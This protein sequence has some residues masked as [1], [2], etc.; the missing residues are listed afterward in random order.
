MIKIFLRPRERERK[1]IKLI[2]Q[3]YFKNTARE[4]SAGGKGEKKK[5]AG[6]GGGGGDGRKC[7]ALLENTDTA[8]EIKCGKGGGGG[9]FFLGGEK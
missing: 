2:V 9:I 1:K 5:K 4:G 8:L 7:I 6:G 3:K